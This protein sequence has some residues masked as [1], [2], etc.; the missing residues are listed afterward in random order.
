MEER[1]VATI[2]RDLVAAERRLASTTDPIAFIAVSGKVRALREEHRAAVA[3][4]KEKN[5]L[6]KAGS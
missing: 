2:L 1:T 6:R 5:P 3:A 4:R